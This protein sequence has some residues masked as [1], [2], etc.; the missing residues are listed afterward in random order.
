MNTKNMKIKEISVGLSGVIPQG[1]YENLRPSYSM[2]VEPINGESPD[3]IFHECENYLHRM[4]DMEANRAKSD[5]IEK[6][7]ASIR[8]YEKDGIKYPSVTSILDLDKTWSVTEDELKQYAA[9]GTIVHAMIETYLETGEWLNPQTTD[10]LREEVAI[11]AGG[12]LQ[13]TWNDC[14]HVES[15]KQ[16]SKKIKSEKFE[17]P[18]FNEQNLYAGTYD[19]VGD[20]DN[21]RSLMDFKSGS[22]RDM[23]QLAAYAVCEKDIKQ[24]VIFPV[25]PTDNKSGCMRPVVCDT[26]QAE[27]KEFLKARAKFK[28]RFGI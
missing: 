24:L 18:V 15:M 20:Y 3:V 17:Q 7:Y 28:S 26:I 4:F 5:L 27:F 6:Q 2:T 13:M 12:S 21:I 8:F 10:Y 11:L 19:L 25:G 23:R 9:R 22:S 14:S 16:F 1:P